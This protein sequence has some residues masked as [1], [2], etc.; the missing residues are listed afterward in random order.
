MLCGFLKYNEI[1][2]HFFHKMPFACVSSFLWQCMVD[3]WKFMGP[4]DRVLQDLSKKPAA[5]RQHSRAVLKSNTYINRI[6]KKEGCFQILGHI[7]L[8]RRN[9]LSFTYPVSISGFLGSF[10][11]ISACWMC[12]WTKSRGMSPLVQ[13]F[14]YWK[15]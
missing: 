2:Y 9:K 5:T 10:S 6:H 3:S 4:R 14:V 8:M 1:S 11:E 13:Q 15:G 12:L 7:Y